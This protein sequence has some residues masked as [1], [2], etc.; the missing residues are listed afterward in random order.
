MGNTQI[1]YD[2]VISVSKVRGVARHKRCLSPRKSTAHVRA[3]IRYKRIYY[4]SCPVIL[5][6]T[7]KDFFTSEFPGCLLVL[8]LLRAQLCHKRVTNLDLG[9]G[10]FTCIF[11][12]SKIVLIC[13]FFVLLFVVPMGNF[14]FSCTASE[15]MRQGKN[16]CHCQKNVVVP[17]LCVKF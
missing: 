15:F 12:L 14:S 3:Y 13:V 6:R 1:L 7:G 17:N 5:C 2:L 10:P 8:L 9:K 4:L 11:K 16:V